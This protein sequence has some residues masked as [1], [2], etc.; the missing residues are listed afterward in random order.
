MIALVVKLDAAD[1]KWTA[2]GATS[3]ASPNRLR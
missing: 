2:S 1:A 3:L